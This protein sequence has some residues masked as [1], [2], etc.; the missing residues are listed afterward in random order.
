[1]RVCVTSAL[2]SASCY[3]R[4]CSVSQQRQKHSSRQRRKNPS[5]QGYQ[6]GCESLEMSNN[7]SR[8]RNNRCYSNNSSSSN[9]WKL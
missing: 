1:M 3:S 6:N 8:R 4:A 7:N 9:K 5:R 2:T